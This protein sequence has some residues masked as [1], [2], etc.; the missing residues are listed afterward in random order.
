MKVKIS[1]F[2]TLLIGI[3]LISSV[4]VLRNVQSVHSVMRLFRFATVPLLFLTVLI[5]LPQQPID[6]IKRMSWL[7]LPP[8]ILL[9]INLLQLFAL[10]AEVL[11]THT[12]GSVRFTAWFLLHIA[13][14]LNINSATVEKI[15]SRTLFVLLLLFVVGIAQYPLIIAQAGGSLGGALSN[16]GQLGA[17]YQL[18]GLFGSAN[19]DA[20][21]FVTLLPLML[22]WIEGRSN[23]KRRI[24]RFVL[25]LYFPFI[26]IFNGTRTAL[27]CSFPIVT[28]LFYWRLS[29]NQL[30]YMAGPLMAVLV[31]LLAASQRFVALFF[32]KESQGG[33][34]LGWRIEHA[35]IPTTD[36]TL[37]NS[38]LFGYGSRGWDFLCQKLG[39]LNPLTREVVPAH[40]GYVWSFVT[41]GSI[42]FLVYITFLLV[43][44]TESFKLSRSDS[45]DISRMGRALLCA[46]VG[47]CFWAFISNVMWPQGWLVLLSLATLI[48][49]LKTTALEAAKDPPLTDSGWDK[50][51]VLSEIET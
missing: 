32:E 30:L 42:G 20:N 25:L 6:K 43:L 4:E 1:D 45:Y 18:S 47:Y 50:P 16:Y 9:S 5:L 21:G 33:G 31:G 22:W 41:W 49:C 15:R 19:E 17:R 14:I 44:L 46:V 28:I 10:P 29:L 12:T 39:I 34:T 37:A 11:P 2:L 35:W 23:P 40:S 36:Y 24:F 8:I 48:A 7:C 27:L 38:P 13:V 26:L 51:L 3:Y